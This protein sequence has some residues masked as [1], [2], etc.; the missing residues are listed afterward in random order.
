MKPLSIFNVGLMSDFDRYLLSEIIKCE[1]EENA[2]RMKTDKY[3]ELFTAEQILK[4]QEFDLDSEQVRS[5]SLGGG[6]DGGVDFIYLFANRRLVREDSELEKFVEQQLSIELI[7][8]QSKHQSSFSEIA[9]QKIEDFAEKCLKFNGESRATLEKLYN[10]K[11]VIAVDMFHN[12]YRMSLTKKPKLSISFFYASLGE[13]VDAKVKERANILVSKCLNSFSTAEVRFEFVGSSKLLE[14][15]NRVATKTLVLKASVATGISSFG[16][17]YICLVPLRNFYEFIT[18]NKQIRSHIFESNVRDYQGDVG[19]N[20][21]I[22]ETLSTEESEE[23]WWLN[24]GVTVIASK[25]TAA[26]TD[27][28]ITDPL[29]VNGLQTSHKI[30]QHFKNNNGTDNRN[31]LVRVIENTSPQSIDRIIKATNSQTKIDKIYLHAT[32]TIHRNIEHALKGVDLYYDRRKNYYR[33]LHKPSA[34]IITMPQLS[35]AVAAIY[36][37]QPNDARARPTTVADKH[38]KHIFAKTHPVALYVKCAQVIRR[39]DDC[40]DAYD[41]AAP[42]K[43]N[44]IFYIAMYAVCLTLKMSKPK[45]SDIASLNIDEI[46]D[47]LIDE[48]YQM[49][50]DLYK[51][52]GGDDRAAKGPRIAEQLKVKLRER[53]VDPLRLARMSSMES[54]KLRAGRNR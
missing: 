1:R 36:L 52:N 39:I 43:N 49:V 34:K 35:Q 24:N 30:F 18:E 11:L 26:G 16:T 17:S 8:L 42:N 51:N 22:A 4:G 9:I 21:E 47:D 3:F 38:Y 46:S 29:I 5:G 33:N 15:Y 44:L 10:Q 13:Q 41:L 20:K 54:D 31:V 27:V 50:G 48:S 6:G 53:F 37:Q 32:E 14:F 2:R 23:F 28:S 40:L 19:V 12:L 45:A 25:V 7:I